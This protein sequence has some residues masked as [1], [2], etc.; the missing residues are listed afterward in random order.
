V[1]FDATAQT[2]GALE[3][4]VISSIVT[5][6]PFKM[7]YVAVQSALEALQGKTLPAVTDTGVALVTLANLA[8]PEVQKIINP[9]K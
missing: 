7:G 5:Q 1:G 8:S 9:L 4:K 2:I 6:V 3:N